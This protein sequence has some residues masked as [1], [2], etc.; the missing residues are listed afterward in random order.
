MYDYDCYN[1]EHYY[2]PSIADE[3]LLEFQQKM[4]NALLEN[5]KLDI[6][7]TKE[8]NARLKEENKKQKQR[9]NDIS[10]KERDLKYKEENLKREVTNEF[11]QSNIGD[12]LKQY[13]EES[14]I[15][16]ADVERYQNEK[17]NLCDEER[18]LVAE[19]PNGKIIKTNC[20]CAK[21][22]SKY[23][24][25][26]SEIK[27]I[28]FSKRDSRYSSERKFYLSRSYSPIPSRRSDYDDYQEFKIYHVINEF[29]ESIIKLH[30]NK[31]YSERLGFRSKEECQKYC[32]WLNNK[33]K[34]KNN[35][36]EELELEDYND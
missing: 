18:K 14:E 34:E 4:K 5:V 3:I 22:L 35:K 24:P 31:E 10:N 32:N 6:Q 15:W 30:K 20:D 8:E 1:D 33:E 9:E 23:V 27:L 2:E 28:K 13:I 26:L 7:N 12:T 17:C 19:Y 36:C 25:G 29:D 11:Y 16:F 21:I